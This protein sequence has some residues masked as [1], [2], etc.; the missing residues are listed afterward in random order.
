[1][2]KH[3]QQLK[4]RLRNRLLQYVKLLAANIKSGK[5]LLMMRRFD[6]SSLE[7]SSQLFETPSPLALLQKVAVV[8]ELATLHA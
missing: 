3:C 2:A 6:S 8:K 7:S 1:M 5:N 4:Q